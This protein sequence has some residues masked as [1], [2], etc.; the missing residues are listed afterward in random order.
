[1]DA[2]KRLGGSTATETHQVPRGG[3]FETSPIVTVVT[4]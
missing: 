3:R 1:M 4:G 2:K